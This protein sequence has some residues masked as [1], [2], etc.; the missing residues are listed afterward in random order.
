[1]GTTQLGA[2]AGDGAAAVRYGAVRYGMVRYECSAVRC[3]AVAVAVA[4][5]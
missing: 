2:G 3:V 1:M 4:V 5:R